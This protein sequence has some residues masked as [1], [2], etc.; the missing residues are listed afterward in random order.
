[1]DTRLSVLPLTRIAKPVKPRKTMLPI[2]QYLWQHQPYYHIRASFPDTNHVGFG[3][4]NIFKSQSQKNKTDLWVKV[5]RP[6]WIMTLRR[7]AESCPF[8]HAKRKKSIQKQQNRCNEQKTT[9][10]NSSSSVKSIVSI[11][12][13]TKTVL[14]QW[15]LHYGSISKTCGKM[16]W[17]CRISYFFQY[18]YYNKG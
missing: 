5:P 2:R 10:K 9:S 17:K 7:L 15:E 1:M 4:N 8:Y 3:A 13:E 12:C 6:S 14:S 11:C 18:K 16:A